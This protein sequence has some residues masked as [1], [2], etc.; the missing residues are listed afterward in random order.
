M[1]KKSDL[2]IMMA[3]NIGQMS[4]LGKMTPLKMPRTVAVAVLLCLL[5]LFFIKC[6]F[7]VS[8]HL[9]SP[10]LVRWE[11]CVLCLWLFLCISIY[12]NIYL[13]K[14]CRSR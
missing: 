11:G 9:L 3:I 4:D 6:C 7:V 8:F 5:G 10:Y 12:Q 1:V 14:Q 2:D 13:C